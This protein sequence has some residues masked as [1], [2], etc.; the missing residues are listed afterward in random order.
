MP[1]R[2]PIHVVA[3]IVAILVV[4]I[5]LV[6][7]SLKSNKKNLERGNFAEFDAPSAPS[8]TQTVAGST[9][10]L[11]STPTSTPATTL[12]SSVTSVRGV[13]F[14]VNISKLDVGSI[15]AF[16]FKFSNEPNTEL[17]KS[18][19]IR[20]PAGWEFT[21]GEVLGQDAIVGKAVLNIV[22]NDRPETT[23]ADVL[24]QKET[25]GHKAHWVVVL[26]GL[27]FDVYIDEEQGDTHMI[28]MERGLIEGI[29][30]PS[31][32]E[33]TIFA[34]LASELIFKGSDT[35]GDYSFQASA[36][37][38]DEDTLQFQKTITVLP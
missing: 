30:P 35:A 18:F 23:E 16:Q 34:N 19:E 38:F 22:I 37:L 17:V 12:A 27:K 20:I 8:L 31:S 14:D 11:L 29:K 9:P 4:F 28:T 6:S 3:L 7:F 15:S 5:G 25:Q 24:N 2:F 26:L 10:N 21:K 1:K 13:S 33:V 36:K 32:I